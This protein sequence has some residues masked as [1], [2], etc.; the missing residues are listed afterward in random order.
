M[1]RNAIALA[2]ALAAALPFAASAQ[3]TPGS[4]HR[5]DVPEWA[6]DRQERRQDVRE[7]QDDRL[8][9]RRAEAL[10]SDYDAAARARRRRAMTQL[11]DQALAILRQE[12][13]EGQAE[14]ARDRGEVAR[15]QQ[16]LRE[17]Q[18]DLMRERRDGDRAG[19]MEE[20]RELRD[21]RRDLRDDRRDAAVEASKLERVR[22]MGDALA[23][24]RGRFRRGQIARKRE[25]LGEMV[26]MA[27]AEVR[28]NR[29]EQREDRRE[30]QEDRRDR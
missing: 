11:E 26:Q 8:D 3:P 2:A 10:L 7:A 15:G 30:L 1:T 25:L 14:L 28:E 17:G 6:R 16:E 19:V 23:S 9:L 5:P 27:R 4:R 20:R 22:Q 24:L 18:R 12:W 13:R 21:D 29:Q